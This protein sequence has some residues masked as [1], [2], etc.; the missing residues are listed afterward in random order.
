MNSLVWIV[1]DSCR[2]DSFIQARKPAVDNFAKFNQ[3]EVERRYSY[4]S[5][6]GPSHYAFL[7]G[8]V[9]HRNESG[10]VASDVYR[11]EFSAW[12][13]RLGVAK[14]DYTQFLPELSLVKVLNESGY[15]TIARVSLPVLNH[16]TM[17][18]SHFHDYR[19]MD[20]H[21]DFQGMIDEMR[22]ESERPRFYL[23][24]V[25][26]THYPYMLRDS[27]LPRISGVHGVLKGLAA[28]STYLQGTRSFDRETMS[29]LHQQQVHCVEYADSLLPQLFDKCPVG[30]HIIITADH[31]ELFG[32][33]NYFGHGPIMHQ[34]VFEVPFIEG[35]VPT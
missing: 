30:T 35:K 24:N 26:V 19:L 18:S 9:P 12:A 15:R 27:S 16:T 25:G 13:G 34:K 28:S 6:T 20:D 31:G 33:D 4:A 29:R 17:I 32:E 5:W 11:H 23:F 14:L 7:T 3:V 8:L 1:L 10:I 2:Y 21:D 22:F